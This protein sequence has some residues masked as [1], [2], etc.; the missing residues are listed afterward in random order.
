MGSV[1]PGAIEIARRHKQAM[2]KPIAKLLP[3]SRRR[4]RDSQAI[5]VAVDGAITIR[6]DAGCCIEGAGPDAAWVAG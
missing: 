6:S 4:E 3:A 2:T 1:L 5:S